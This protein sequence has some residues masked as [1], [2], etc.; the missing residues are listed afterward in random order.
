MRFLILFI[1]T[2][3][4]AYATT[5]ACQTL[6]EDTKTYTHCTTRIGTY[7]NIVHIYIPKGLVDDELVSLNIHFHGFN[8]GY[9]HFDKT[10]G[11]YGHYLAESGH[12][13]ILIIPESDGKCATYDKYFKN[14]NLISFVEESKKILSPLKID[15]LSF[16]AHSGAYKVLNVIFGIDQLEK[17]IGEIKG[18]AL[19][20]ATYGS[21]INIENFVA[22]KIKEK[23]L[24]LFFDSYLVGTLTEKLSNTVKS[25]LDKISLNSEHKKNIK[26]IPVLRGNRSPIE[27][28]FGILRDHGV[29]EFFTGLKSLK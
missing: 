22:N 13:T 8:I 15:S 6:V 18:V 28:H 4:H 20:D 1:L 5:P 2:T 17:S 14:Q 27:A 3:F 24:F 19:Y 7:P 9:N 21:I 25:R 29:L 26:F 16:S 10:F 23:K 11:D 12:P